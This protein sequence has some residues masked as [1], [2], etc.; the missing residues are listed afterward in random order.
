MLAGDARALS[1][2]MDRYD[3]LVRYAIYRLSKDHCARDPQWLDGLASGVWAAFVDS[4]RRG[5]RSLPAS[6]PT[7][8]VTVA[9][10]HAVS[11]LRKATRSRDQAGGSPQDL[12]TAAVTEG[13]ASAILQKIELL[14]RLHECVL[15]LDADDR[16]IIGELSAIMDRRW[17]DAA[18]SLG[19]SESTLRSQWKRLLVRLREA[20][21][22][23]TG[24][25]IAPGLDEGDF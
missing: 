1:V 10:N 3:R 9:R 17:R 6:V 2:L 20:F 13:D 11:G 15:D 8:L 19:R 24:V 12:E 23:R 25:S 4:A 14:A 22:Q 16:L 5:G 21:S 7:F 18:G